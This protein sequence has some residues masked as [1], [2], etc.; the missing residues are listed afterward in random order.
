M[1]V[2]LWIVIVVGSLVLQAT[3]IP[4]VSYQG[5]WPDLLLILVVSS[6][7]LLGKEQGVCIGFFSGL[8][9]DLAGGN[10]F[11]VNTLSKLMIGYLFGLA[12]RQV[13]KEHFLLPVLAM[14]IAT[15]LNNAVTFIIL[16]LLGYKIEL[17]PAIVN[18]L[19]PLMIYHVIVAIPVHRVI[20]RVSK[21]K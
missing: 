13:F 10:I 3:I 7:L 21:I 6:S 18:N 12:E 15:V 17:V 1:K 9:Q 20:Y 4:L 8:L 19:L 11:G 5:V 16:L 2:V 14:C